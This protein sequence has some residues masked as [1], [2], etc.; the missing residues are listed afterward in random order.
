MAL[1]APSYV[2]HDRLLMEQVNMERYGWDLGI[3]G[4]PTQVGLYFFDLAALPYRVLSRPM[5]RIDGSAGKYLPGDN[6]PL[7]LYPES[8]S[9]TG[10]AGMAGAYTG[11]PFVFKW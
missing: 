7:L 2:L 3:L 6:V 4:P 11:V 5:D 1:V 8:F 9:L 10:W